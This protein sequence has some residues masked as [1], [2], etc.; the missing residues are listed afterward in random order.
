[1]HNHRPWLPCSK[2]EQAALEARQAQLADAADA[3]EQRE[4]GERQRQQQGSQSRQQ[5][6]PGQQGQEEARGLAQLGRDGALAEQHWQAG[7]QQAAGQLHLCAE[8]AAAQAGLASPAV[9]LQEEQQQQPGSEHL[10][11]EGSADGG[12]RPRHRKPQAHRALA[13]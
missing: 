6:E 12:P 5:L 9:A 10:G 7:R 13:S 3:R 2:Q 11:Q 1:M 8:Q 4:Q